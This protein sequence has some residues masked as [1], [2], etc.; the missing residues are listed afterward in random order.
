MLPHPLQFSESEEKLAV[1]RHA[2]GPQHVPSPP[3]SRQ[4]EPGAAVAQS[5]GGDVH[6]PLTQISP[7]E[8]Q[9]VLQNEQLF[10]SV[11]MS[12]HVPPQHMPVSVAETKQY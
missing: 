5:C 12:T 4:G 1:G 6:C 11:S 2:P 8:E 3:S 9:G 7:A 10:G